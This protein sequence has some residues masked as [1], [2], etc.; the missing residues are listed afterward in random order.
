MNI[1]VKRVI[2]RYD[3]TSEIIDEIW[4]KE[5]YDEIRM[6]RELFRF[7]KNYPIFQLNPELTEFLP[8]C[9]TQE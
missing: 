7:N 5:A 2:K 4:E 6:K 8:Q 9:E 1:P 3:L